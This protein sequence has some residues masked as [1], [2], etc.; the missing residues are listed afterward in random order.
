MDRAAASAR[1]A[2]SSL[3]RSCL[4]ASPACPVQQRKQFVDI[5]ASL[6]STALHSVKQ[7]NLSDPWAAMLHTC[8]QAAVASTARSNLGTQH[9]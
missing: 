8:K 2:A 5:V 3:L 6:V 7:R 4:A 9:S 1:A